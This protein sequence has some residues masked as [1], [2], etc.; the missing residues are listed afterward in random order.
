M[1]TRFKVQQNVHATLEL[2]QTYKKLFFEQSN[3]RVEQ[4]SK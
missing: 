3:K 4:S 1:K 2:D